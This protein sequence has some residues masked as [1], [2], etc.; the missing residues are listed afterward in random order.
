[1]SNKVISFQ[2]INISAFLSHEIKIIK[3][4]IETFPLE[5]IGPAPQFLYAIENKIES[6]IL[7]WRHT[8]IK[9]WANKLP[10]AV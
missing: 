6:L 3:T 10:I 8:Q 1:M 7:S 5:K 4:N 9:Q 2:T